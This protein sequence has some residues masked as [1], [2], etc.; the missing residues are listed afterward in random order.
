[1]KLDHSP[2]LLCAILATAL[3]ADAAAQNPV[4]KVPAPPQATPDLKLSPAPTVKAAAN[5]QAAQVAPGVLAG[6]AAA[7]VAAPPNLPAGATDLPAEVL[8]DDQAETLRAVGNTYKAEFDRSGAAYVPYFDGA[9]RNHPLHFTVQR[10]VVGGQEL[11]IAGARRVR[12]GNRVSFAHGGLR[13][14]YDLLP[15]GMEQMFWFDALPARGELCVEVALGTDLGAEAHDGGL[16]FTNQLGTVNYGRAVAIDANGDRLPLELTLEHGT[17]RFLVPA[18]FVA[19]AQLPLC[20]DPVVSSEQL[21]YQGASPHPAEASDIAYEPS[22]GEY[23]VVF[24]R[25]WSGTDYDVFV[26]RFSAQMNPLTLHI[27]DSS[28]TESWQVPKIAANN[29][30]DRFLVV[31]QTSNGAVSPFW[32]AGRTV[33]AV[34]GT[35]GAPFTIERAGLPG[36]AAGDKINPDV[37]GDPDYFAPSYFTVVWERVYSPTDHDVHMKQVFDNGGIRSAT[38]TLI[39]NSGAFDSQPSISKSNGSRPLATQCWGVVWQRQVT[40]SDED[41]FGSLVRWDGTITVPTFMVDAPSAW[42]LHPAISSPT[43]EVNG[44]R[45]Y[46]CAFD[47][48]LPGNSTITARMLDQNGAHRGRYDI[49]N[50]VTP[51]WPH[52]EPSVDSDGA[53]FVVGWHEVYSGTGQDF[54]VRVATCAFTPAVGL[55]IQDMDAP[56]YTTNLES[57]CELASTHVD[58]A[59]GGR[60]GVT[61]TR[62]SATSRD[63]YARTYDG[64]QAGATTSWRTTACGTEAAFTVLGAPYLGSWV[65]AGQSVATG[66]RGYVF[67][68]P[69]SQPIGACPGCLLGVQGDTVIVDPVTIYIP[70]NPYLVGL[71]FALQAFQFGNGPC[72]G[73]VSLSDTLD[74][75]VR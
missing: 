30:S 2:R 45:F 46:L 11:P 59:T 6:A 43:D 16:R 26:R 69:T 52:V 55:L 47:D 29:V 5:T 56:A 42:Q 73:A 63:I 57:L 12:P 20:I 65:Y 53:R 33:D 1:M 32:I 7:K 17:L 15:R 60:Y 23:Q 70:N 71:T 51:G 31:A 49:G 66:L 48:Q 25:Y 35:V 13:A 22:Y 38:P 74:I 34:S 64:V 8:F 58:G 3:A 44:E 62:S 41:I 27:I 36:H 39:D 10:A 72:L 9:D 40:A 18:A 54:D 4:A 67:G 21:A 61:W 50:Q 68:A 24:Q 19:N 14:T 75:T 28:T 37:G